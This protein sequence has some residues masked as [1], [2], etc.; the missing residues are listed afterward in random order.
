MDSNT[1]KFIEYVQAKCKEH[2]IK[3]ELRDV[4]KLKISGNIYS[5][6]YFMD[7]EYDGRAKLIVAKKRKDWLNLLLHEFCHAEQWI[8]NIK[9]WDKVR[10]N[11]MDEWLNG[12][13]IH[14]PHTHLDDM[15][16]LELDCEKRAVQNIRK[17]N[18]PINIQEYTQ[19]ANSYVLFYNYI[20]ETRNWSKPG[21]SPYQNKELWS[22]C[23]KKFMPLKYYKIIPYKIY[24]KFIDCKI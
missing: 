7:N 11:K 3:V 1:L 18:L 21:N 22:V 17:F 12:D 15:K 13:K 10:N 23:P 20:K 9:L 4:N 14:Y 2:N 19:K 16:L 6:G 8:E 24:K 5:G